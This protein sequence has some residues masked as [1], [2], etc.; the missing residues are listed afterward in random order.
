MWSNDN[1]SGDEEEFF[2][3]LMQR[4][5]SHVFY[6]RIVP[7]LTVAETNS[8][9]IFGMCLRNSKVIQKNLLTK[10]EF[11]FLHYIDPKVWNRIYMS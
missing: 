6:S 1:K 4:I 9:S 10:E 11:D 2:C 3:S 7:F 5:G 8:C